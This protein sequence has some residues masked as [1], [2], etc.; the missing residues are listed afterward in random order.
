MGEGTSSAASRFW[1]RV[2]HRSGI[3]LIHT[4][5]GR[6]FLYWDIEPVWLKQVSR[7]FSTDWTRLDYYVAVGDEEGRVE[8]VRRLTAETRS[9]HLE[10]PHLDSAGSWGEWGIWANGG[11][12]LILLRTPGTHF[13]PSGEPWSASFDGY[14]EA[15]PFPLDGGG[16]YVGG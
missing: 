3:W 6:I 9:I 5:P 16:D 10:V 12:L 1:D 15:R 14:G 4:A 11:R 13:G 7:H 2:G 8:T